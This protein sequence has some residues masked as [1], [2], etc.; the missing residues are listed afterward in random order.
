MSYLLIMFLYNFYSFRQVMS[1]EELN[2]NLSN[3][4]TYAL[5]FT[6]TATFG[7]KSRDRVRKH[8]FKQA[9]LIEVL[10]SEQ[11]NIIKTFP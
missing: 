5:I 10:S 9:L 4:V 2:E 3:F 1:S 8:T 11:E 6:T 7:A